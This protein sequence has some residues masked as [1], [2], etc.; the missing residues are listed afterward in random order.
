MSLSN[1]LTNRCLYLP[2]I[3][4]KNNRVILGKGAKLFGYVEMRGEKNR[5]ILAEGAFLSGR[6]FVK[7]SGL[8][9]SIGSNTSVR[10]GYILVQEGADLTIGSDCLISR[11]VEIRT[12]DAHSLVDI[13]N[14]KRINPAQPVVIGDHVWIGARSFIS[15]GS[16]IPDKCVVGAMSFVNKS[17]EGEGHLLAGVPARI[18]RSG[19]T[20]HRERRRRFAR[21]DL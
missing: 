1:F 21:D 9:V 7:G 11:D 3:S 20:W 10:Q 18:V 17:F 12:S 2:R 8:T 14:G 13:K 16:T 5:I 19:I 15:K 6:I 4:G